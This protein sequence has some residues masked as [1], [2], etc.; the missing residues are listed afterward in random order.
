MNATNEG[1]TVKAYETNDGQIYL[2]DGGLV[3]SH[4]EQHD[5]PGMLVNDITNFDACAENAT[6]ASTYVQM[7]D[8]LEHP[9][10]K[11]IAEYDGE[12]VKINLFAMGNE[13]CRYAGVER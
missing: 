1:N 10:T 4:F 2:T 6:D 9:D 12:T 13:G 8:V 5:K 11:V 3:L 7:E